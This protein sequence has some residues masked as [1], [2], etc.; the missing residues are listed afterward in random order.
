MDPQDAIDLGREAIR[1]CIS[2]GSPIL[3]ASL[4]I[5]LVVS[6]LQSMTQLHD[7]AIAFAPKVL[8]LL[9]TI[10]VCLPWLSDKMLEF[11]KYSLEK[12]VVFQTPSSNGF[13][14]NDNTSAKRTLNYPALEYKWA[15]APEA[16]LSKAAAPV[17]TKRTGMPMLRSNQPTSQPQFRSQP[18]MK[19]RVASPFALPAYRTAE[20]ETPEQASETPAVETKTF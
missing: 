5:G 13:E 15:G 2:V 11:T 4:L 12:P 19:P 17:P 20:A 7:Q 16:S 3:I 18:P 1:T 10:A 14:V 9:V 8:L 6:L